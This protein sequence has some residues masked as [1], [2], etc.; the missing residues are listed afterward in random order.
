M[1][2]NPYSYVLFYGF[3]VVSGLHKSAQL[4]HDMPSPRPSP[5]HQPAVSSLMGDDSIS[6]DDDDDDIEEKLT[7][8][9]SRMKELFPHLDRMDALP[10]ESAHVKRRILSF[11]R[12]SWKRTHLLD[13]LYKRVQRLPAVADLFR[14]FL[15]GRIE[16]SEAF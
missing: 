10:E 2:F 1:Q 15:V 14:A 4:T 7:T 12:S 6:D 11:Y 3:Q 8:H 16:Y 9:F 13:L 5:A